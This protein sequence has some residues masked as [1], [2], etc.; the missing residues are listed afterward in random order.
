MKRLQLSGWSAALVIV[1]GFVPLEA[2]DIGADDDHKPTPA[3]TKSSPMPPSSSEDKKFRDFNDVVKG[4]QKHEGF[5]NL[6]LKDDHLYAEIG[7]HQFDQ[8][9]LMPIAI[10]RGLAMAG[11]PL[12]FGDEWVLSLHRVG[13][14]VQL[15]RKNTHFKA[16]SDASLDKAVK[17]NYTDSILMA[18]PILSINAMGGQGVL[19][20]FSDIFLG[21]FAQLN[22]GYLDRN[23]T[24]Y[25]KIKSFPNNVEIE[26]EATFGGSGGGQYLMF[27]GGSDGVIDQRGKTVVI[28]YSIAKI[29]DAGYHVRL[30]DDR[31]GHFLNSTRDFGLNDPDSTRVRMINRWR[32]EKS[33]P[34]AKL[35]PPKKQ[36]VWY[37]EDTVPHEYR[38]Y[39]EEGIRE[40]NKAFEKIGFREAISVRWQESGRDDFDPEDINYCT[41]RWITTN[42]TYAMSCLRSNPLSGEMIDGDV[43]F[44]A[45]WIRTWKEQYAFLTGSV[46]PTGRDG[47]SSPSREPLSVGRILSPIMAAKEGFGLPFPLAKARGSLLSETTRTG[48]PRPELVPSEWNEL[49]AK[50]RQRQSAGKLT[51]CT[52][53]YGMRPELGLAAL[54]LAADDKDKDKDKEKKE[55]EA[56]LPDEMMGQLIKEV[57]M[58]EVGHSLGLRHNFKAS[59]MLTAEQ[60]NDTSITRVKGMAGS[61]MDYNPINIAPKGQKQGDYTTTTIGPYDYWAIEYA[62]KPINGDEATELKKIAT[63]SPEADLV[64]ATDEDMM[65]NDDPLV[66]TYDLGSDT[67]R[68]A[69]DRIALATELLKDLDAKVIKDGESFAR[70]REAFSIL[71]NQWGNGAFLVVSNVGGQSVSRDHK[72]KAARDPVVPVAAAKQRESLAFLV[73]QI[74]S[75]KAFKF[76]PSLLRRLG[77][78]KWY[79]GSGFF[80]GGGIDYPVNEELLGIQ[81]IVL[82]RCLSA[83]VLSRLANQELQV[84]AG[85]DALRPSEV[86]RSLTDGIFAELNN[87]TATPGVAK[88][89]AFALS[90]IRRNLQREYLRRLSTMVL[91][92]RRS[93]YNDM[94]AFVIFLGNQSYPADARSLARLHLKEINSKIGKVLD[95]KEIPIDDTT[96]AHLEESKFRIS[97]VLDAG[98]D[99]NEP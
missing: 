47:A 53:T 39:V 30:A 24:S 29:P 42:M 40:W 70:V 31:V 82:G 90:T 71:L 66:N 96:R 6:H 23:R 46:I 87:P 50:L 52:F 62:Y 8:P 91:G 19:V 37:V 13:D 83:D 5:F 49:H 95:Q 25:H 26:V 65:L 81:K 21:D 72:G 18:L 58:H 51:A 85:A 38:P 44:D 28:H 16:P 84:E 15:I 7:P 76:S 97:K 45:S 92:D 55:P 9:F 1:L 10:A 60:L 14:K 86:Y 80:Y 4:A 17:Q 33:D 12:N 73:D 99:S 69:K 59:T 48:S 32:L 88:D 75:D 78:D 64:F 57:V 89:K 20:D 11:Q 2:Q 74:L 67:L 27:G 35:S 3:K 79:D 22:F 41:F 77:S 94:F 56:K 43:I 34:K 98:I 36:I 68:F 54:A 61:V 93:P 63:R